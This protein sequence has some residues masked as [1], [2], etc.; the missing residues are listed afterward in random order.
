MADD[1][2]TD[3]LTALMALAA[4]LRDT[5]GAVAERAD[6]AAR[7]LGSQSSAGSKSTQEDPTWASA[8]FG[9][10]IDFAGV[11]RES[12][13]VELRERLSTSVHDTL[14]SARALIDWYLERETAAA[15]ESSGATGGVDGVID[16]EPGADRSDDGGAG[17]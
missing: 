5:A 10:L 15:A 6:A 11:L 16:G 8:D 3:A 17:S 12:V 7:D 4:R 13:P 9:A 1:R 2:N 14:I